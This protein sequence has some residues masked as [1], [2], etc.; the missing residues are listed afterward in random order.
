MSEAK[1]K[2]DDLIDKFKKECPGMETYWAKQ[3]A[4]IH[5]KGVLE[6]LNP[7]N[8]QNDISNRVELWKEVKQELEKL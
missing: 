5:V 1:K 6:E 8:F 3:C 2:A 7:S 4:L